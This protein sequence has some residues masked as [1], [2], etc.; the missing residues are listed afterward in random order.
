LNSIKLQNKRIFMK[1]SRILGYRYI[2]CGVT[3]VDLNLVSF[4]MYPNAYR[5]KEM[6]TKD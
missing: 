4:T 1:M 2:N 6:S 3:K 5:H